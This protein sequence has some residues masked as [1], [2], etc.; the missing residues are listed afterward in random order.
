E[1]PLQPPVSAGGSEEPLQ[2]P[3]SAG[4]SEE[5][6]QPPVSAGGSEESLQPSLPAGGPVE[7]VQ[8]HASSAGGPKEPVQS[9]AT[10]AGGPEEPI[11]P[12]LA[13]SSQDLCRQKHTD[14]A[15]VLTVKENAAIAAVTNRVWF[16]LFKDSWVW[17]DGTKT[18]FRYWKR[19][20]NYSGNCVSVEGS[21]TGRWVPADCNQ[22]ATFICQGGKFLK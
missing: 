15:C 17:S 6:L 10:S 2:P 19:G 11:Q 5:P 20:G 1:E 4:G 12:P 22:K 7:P 16:G 8:P 3:V 18:S 13:S 14:L 21:Q 9:H